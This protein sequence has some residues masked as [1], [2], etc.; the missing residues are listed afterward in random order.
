MM[1][2]VDDLKCA[3][4]ESS[5]KHILTILMILS[6]HALLLIMHLRWD[7][8]SLSGPGVNKL[9][10]LAMAFMNSSLENE[11]YSSRALLGN[12]SR[13][14]ILTWWSCVRLNIE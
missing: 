9:L 1:I 8:D 12:S 13:I 11:G 2:V 14:L 10:H 7:H 4:H 3:G 6:R 5:S